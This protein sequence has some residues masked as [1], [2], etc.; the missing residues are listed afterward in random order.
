MHDGRSTTLAEAIIE[1]GSAGDNTSEGRFARANFIN[2]STSQRRALVAYLENL[3][4]F[5]IEEEEEAAAAAGPLSLLQ[6]PSG[7]RQKVKI[8]PKGFRIRMQ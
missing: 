2:A 4:L 8:S 3:V 6:A 7:P 1:H 5:K